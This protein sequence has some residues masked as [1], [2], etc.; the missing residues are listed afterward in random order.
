LVSLL[1]AEHGQYRR[2]LRL[3][4]RQ[5]SYMKR[6][7]VD[8]LEANAVEWARH[9]PEADQ[10]RIARERYVAELARRVGLAIPPGRVSDLL[11]YTEPETKRRVGT[12]L[13]ALRQ[14][15]ATLARQ[16]TLNRSLAEF[17][18]DLAHEESEIFRKCALED[19][20]GCYGDDAKATGRGPGGFLVKQA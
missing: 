3:A 5:N 4:W 2:L 7:D 15:A 18:L 13:N 8:R 16:N 12:S 11:D 20:A 6:Q 10:S 9:L 14:T 1:E 17:C 19:P